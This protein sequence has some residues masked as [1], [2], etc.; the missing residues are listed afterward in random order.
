[1]PTSHRI[2]SAMLS[3]RRYVCVLG[4]V[5][6]SLLPGCVLLPIPHDQW[7]SP[8]FHGTIIDAQSHLPLKGVKITLQG[9]GFK[10]D[11]VGLVVAYS[12]NNG[13]YLIV[14]KRHSDW[15]PIWLGPAEGPQ[16]GTLLFEFP[17]YQT[18]EDTE[19]RFA[20]AGA[21]IEI[22]VPMVMSKSVPN[23]S[24]DPTPAS[25]TSPAEQEPRLR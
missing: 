24:P 12:G 8:R 6:L 21:R 14:A 11:D 18:E 16:S 4:V 23:Q 10:E 9:Y 13:Q 1:M 5:A 2:G 20:G 22:E 25:G 17:G 3:Q 19:H 7:L 15:L